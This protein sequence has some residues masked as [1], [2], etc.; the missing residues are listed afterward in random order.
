MSSGWLLLHQCNDCTVFE[1]EEKA[2]AAA[3]ELKEQQKEEQEDTEPIFRKD[4][5]KVSKAALR[6]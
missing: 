3:E 5:L 6:P 2:A 1:A 4:S